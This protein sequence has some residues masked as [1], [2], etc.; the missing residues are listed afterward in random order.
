MV[1]FLLTIYVLDIL[2]LS[3]FLFLIPIIWFFSF[4][5]TLQQASKAEEG[6]IEDVPVIKNFMNHQRW[7]GIALIALGAFYLLDDILVPLLS[8]KIQAAF[9]IDIQYFYYRFF[10]MFVVSILL[11]GGGIKLLIGSRSKKGDQD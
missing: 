1:G 11:I 7:I 6:T 2:R 4:F 10:Q 8:S 9:N 5:D 3:V